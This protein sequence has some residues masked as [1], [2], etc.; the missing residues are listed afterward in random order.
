MPTWSKTVSMFEED[1][2]NEN[3]IGVTEY[4]TSMSDI[5]PTNI[6]LKLS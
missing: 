4:I 6:F 1:A 2:F 3:N 5:T